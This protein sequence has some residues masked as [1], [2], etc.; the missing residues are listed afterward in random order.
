VY[1]NSVNKAG[2]IG[3][4]KVELTALDDASDPTKGVANAK[5]LTQQ[6]GVSAIFVFLSNVIVAAA[7]VIKETQTPAI[8]QAGTVSLINPATPEL[9]LGDILISSESVPQFAF[10]KTLV[11]GAAKVGMMEIAT[12][13][14]AGWVTN[15]TA[16]AK[17]NGW[18]VVGNQPV[19]LTAT[20]A[21]AQA[22]AIAA[23]H[24]D[25][26]FMALVD[27]QAISAVNTLRQQGYTGPIINY[28]GGNAL[29][30][31]QHLHDPGFYV[32]RSFPYATA[33]STGAVAEYASAAKA[34]GLD[35]NEAFLINGYVQA[36]ILARA[37][38]NCG[39][40]CPSSKTIAALQ[41]LG[42]VDT[43][44]LTFGPWVYTKTNHAGIQDVEMYHW[45]PSAKAP[46]AASG[47]LSIPSDK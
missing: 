1:F 8:T 45:S 13:A 32:V 3:G 25:V 23:E 9:Y 5:Q 26:V 14:T 29:S 34:A 43:G 18:P 33:S 15:I 46:A 24:P 10:A 12:A 27:S 11:H 35:P 28:N 19:Q 17:A 40:P 30:T 16:L 20:T 38:K 44:G 41:N 36:D 42:S 31:L 39:Y 22:T 2:G 6:D 37:L 21:T 7:P 4:H 47:L